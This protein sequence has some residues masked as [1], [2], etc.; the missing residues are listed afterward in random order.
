MW[1]QEMDILSWSSTFEE[2]FCEGTFYFSLNHV[3]NV[4]KPYLTQLSSCTLYWTWSI[5][6]Y[7]STLGL[8]LGVLAEESEVT[9]NNRP[10]PPF[11][12][13]WCCLLH[14]LSSIYTP[15]LWTHRPRRTKLVE[16]D[17]R[18]DR[19][20]LCRETNSRTRKL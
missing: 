2:I 3:S 10:H 20:P 7:S 18:T 15:S 11:L 19:I 14:V 4:P 9:R 13:Q 16:E 8:Y 12:H 5:L 1:T 6:G 17:G